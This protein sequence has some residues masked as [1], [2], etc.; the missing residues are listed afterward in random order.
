MCI[1]NMGIMDYLRR[2]SRR[3]GDPKGER[4]RLFARDSPARIS[5]GSLVRVTYRANRSSPS[6]ATF[7]GVLL[8]IRRS[9]GNPTILVRGLIDEVGVEQVFCIFS[10]LLEE[11]EVLQPPAKR[12][13]R[14]RYHLRD[15][16]AE[17]LELQ[18]A[19]RPGRGSPPAK[20]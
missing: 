12:S 17:I 16:P 13:D 20:K 2:E 19:A 18:R 8:A 5:T 10:P 3:Q 1:K 9:P 11:I 4:W 6:S 14:K 7:T 15:R